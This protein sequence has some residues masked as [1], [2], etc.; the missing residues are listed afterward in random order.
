MRDSLILNGARG[1]IILIANIAVEVGV[2]GEISKLMS[3]LMFDWGLMVG[4]AADEF[5]R[6]DIGSALFFAFRVLVARTIGVIGLGA[7][8]VTLAGART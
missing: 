5:V 1:L 6:V 4:G 7:T 3:D 2:E 8:T